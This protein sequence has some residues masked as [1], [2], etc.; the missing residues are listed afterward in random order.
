MYVLI[1]EVYDNYVDCSFGNKQVLC[2]ADDLD[3]IENYCKTNFK[4][5]LCDLEC[6]RGHN[7]VDD[8]FD[9]YNCTCNLIVESVEV[10]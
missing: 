1:Q 5:S 9:E 10:L 8:V 7:Q 3:K 4:M 2:V 6:L